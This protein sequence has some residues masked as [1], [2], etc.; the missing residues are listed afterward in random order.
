MNVKEFVKASGKKRKREFATSCQPYKAGYLH[1]R[2]KRG[3]R[4]I[5]VSHIARGFVSAIAIHV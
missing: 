4:P 1:A 2:G 3:P 5:T